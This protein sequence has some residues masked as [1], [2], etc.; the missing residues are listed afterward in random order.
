MEN[1]VN[2][3]QISAENITVS[4]TCSKLNYLVLVTVSIIK[5]C[6]LKII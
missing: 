6:Q 2:F 4:E 5:I 1:K 3:T